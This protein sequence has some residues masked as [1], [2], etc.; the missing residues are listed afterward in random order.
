M[1]NLISR[2]YE[3]RPCKCRAV[4]SNKQISIPLVKLSPMFMLN[5]VNKSC[6]DKVALDNCY[7]LTYFNTLQRTFVEL[8]NVNDFTR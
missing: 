8:T 6:N 4:V 2:K 7:N 1:L 5:L 3:I